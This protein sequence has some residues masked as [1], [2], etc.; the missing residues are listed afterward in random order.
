MKIALS[1]YSLEGLKKQGVDQ[2]EM[3]R[4]AARLGFDAVEIV[5]LDAPAGMD[6]EQWALTLRE[7]AEQEGLPIS[8]YT[9]SSD[10]LRWSGSVEAETER[11]CYQI[12][13]AR[14]LGAVSVR[15][16]VTQGPVGAFQSYD[17]MLPVLAKACWDTAEYGKSLGILVMTENH[18][19]YSQ[20]SDRV[21]RLLAAVNHP[22]FGLLLDMGNFLCVDEDPVKAVGR[23]APYAR[24]VHAK[25]FIIRSGMW[26]DPGE[27]FLR[28]RGGNY[29]KGTIVGQ[30][31]V[32]VRQCLQILKNVGYDGMLG[33]EFE[34]MEEPERAVRIGLANLRRYCDIL[35]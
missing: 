20:D 22:N 25:D 29:I 31:N 12:R 17:Q 14:I 24:Y 7:T 10:L 15:H 8:N 35:Y 3:I 16:D 33:L 30:G 2:R 34:G 9:F 28:S 26:D 11:I 1:T 5:G 23:L 6:E 32:P 27:G 18:G 19:Y 21:E 13:M 4:K